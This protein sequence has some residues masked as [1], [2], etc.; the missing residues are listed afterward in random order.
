MGLTSRQLYERERSDNQ[1]QIQEMVLQSV[2]QARQ[3]QVKDF[4]QVCDRLEKK[5]ADGPL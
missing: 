1:K 5:Y 3:G 2:K 4:D